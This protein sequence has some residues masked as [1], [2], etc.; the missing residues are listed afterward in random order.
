MYAI[1]FWIDITE[2]YYYYFSMNTIHLLL[3]GGFS[4][5]L[6]CDTENAKNIITTP[7]KYVSEP[8]FIA[9]VES[10]LYWSCSKWCFTLW[11]CLLVPYRKEKNVYSKEFQRPFTEFMVLIFVLVEYMNM[12]MN[13]RSLFLISIEN[14]IVIRQPNKHTQIGMQMNFWGV[15]SLNNKLYVFF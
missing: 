2:H 1:S 15:G 11:K 13:L 8:K 9:I 5:N 7:F 10:L 6:F 4:F 12:T 14:I 3:Y